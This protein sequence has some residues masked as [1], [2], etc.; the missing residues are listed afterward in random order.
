[1]ERVFSSEKNGLTCKKWEIKILNL[2][3]VLSWKN[4]A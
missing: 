2:P 3:D 4:E 1:M